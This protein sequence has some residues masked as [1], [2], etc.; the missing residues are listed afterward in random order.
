MARLGLHKN[1]ILN[2]GSRETDS[3]TV[4]EKVMLDRADTG[5]A[6]TVTATAIAGIYS[7]AT[8]FAAGNKSLQEFAFTFTYTEPC[9]CNGLQ[10]CGG[11]GDPACPAGCACTGGVCVS[12]SPPPPTCTD[13]WDE[14]LMAC[15][16]LTAQTLMTGETVAYNY[17]SST[18]Y[19]MST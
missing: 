5:S 8:T 3:F 15:K 11:E 7:S 17:T 9:P 14:A 10:T 2:T 4:I 16:L 18:V 19:L 1:L 13:A 12:A 6:S